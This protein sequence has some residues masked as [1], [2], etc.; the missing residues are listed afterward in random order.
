[1]SKS[2]NFD[3]QLGRRLRAQRLAH[4]LSQ[5]ELADKL[6]ITFQQV[7]KYEKGT[8]RLTAARMRELSAIFD[9]PISTL[10][11]EHPP[12]MTVDRGLDAHDFIT[13]SRAIR[14]L[15]SFNRIKDAKIQ[16]LVAELTDILAS[17]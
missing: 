2:H 8:N 1:M 10:Y 14:L 7:Q 15:R 13:S 3:I 17:K 11:G 4:G 5:E 9:I 6:D 12:K 16:N